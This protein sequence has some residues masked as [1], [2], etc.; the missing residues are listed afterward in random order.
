[1][2]LR[3]L[4]PLA[5]G[6]TVLSRSA[7]AG[8][9][10]TMGAVQVVS[11]PADVRTGVLESDTVISVFAERQNHTLV[12]N[13]NADITAPGESPLSGDPSNLNL[14]PGSLLA[15]TVVDSYFV[16]LDPISQTFL[17]GSISFDRD[18]LGL[19]LSDDT[20]EASHAALGFPGTIYDRLGKVEIGQDS[21]VLR[22]DR[23]TVSFALN[24]L[25]NRDTMRIVTA[26]V[27][28]PG[29]ALLLGLGGAT[30][31]AARRRRLRIA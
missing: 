29:A 18:V 31:L 14:S 21:I 26:A 19:I 6:L 30:L 9:V 1:M 23:R 16:H 25:P 10:S 28:E 11:P 15:G 24:A 20:L 8:I 13:V 2:K 22:A 17:E 3:T 5:L 7:L 27:P 12:G 4:S